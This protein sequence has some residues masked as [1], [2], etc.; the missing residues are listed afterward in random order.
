MG[1]GWLADR[2]YSGV[3][4]A[5]FGRQQEI[6]IG[7]MSGMSNVKFWLAMRGIEATDELCR[8][9]LSYAKSS[10]RVLSQDKVL[11]LVKR[12]R[13]RAKPVRAGR[14]AARVARV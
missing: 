8:K 13:A 12:H 2:V 3:P 11:A 10:P 14:A 6:E 4:A 1:D 9:I 7:H 5:E